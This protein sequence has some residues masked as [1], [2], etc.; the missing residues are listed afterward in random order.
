MWR[1]YDDAPCRRYSTDFQLFFHVIPILFGRFSSSVRNVGINY[2]CSGTDIFSTIITHVSWKQEVAH[3]G[4]MISPIN[5]SL[6]TPGICRTSAN[7][8]CTS[9]VIENMR[10]GHRGKKNNWF[11]K[12]N[13]LQRGWTKWLTFWF[14]KRV[15]EMNVTTTCDKLKC[16]VQCTKGNNT[17][18]LYMCGK[19]CEFVWI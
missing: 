11:S 7:S 19:D 18:R 4:L 2:C 1:V 8:S 14:E 10:L 16:T 17:R 9:K 5:G 6:Y 12:C 13:M 3:L 15:V